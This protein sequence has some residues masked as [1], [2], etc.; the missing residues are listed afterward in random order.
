MSLRF[1]AQQG[2]FDRIQTRLIRFDFFGVGSFQFLK[3]LGQFTN[4]VGTKLTLRI[5]LQLGQTGL[6]GFQLRLDLNATGVQ[7]IE[8]FRRPSI[9]LWAVSVVVRLVDISH[10]FLTKAFNIIVDFGRKILPIE[11]QEFYQTRPAFGAN[12]FERSQSAN[13]S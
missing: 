7:C 11:F 12:G 2:F 8:C 13:K 9:A 3:H 10:D 1:D 6:L 4:V 5:A